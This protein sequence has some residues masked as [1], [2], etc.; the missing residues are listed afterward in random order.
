MYDYP[1]ITNHIP[2]YQEFDGDG[3]TIN[4][5][6][7]GYKGKSLHAV[8][9]RQDIEG[10]Q[11]AFDLGWIDPKTPH[12]MQTIGY[13]SLLDMAIRRGLSK[14]AAKLEEL[15]FSRAPGPN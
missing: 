6:M 5:D 13:S 11:K 15:G 14:T 12:H 8:I 4:H 10:I 2:G 9:T 3:N 7:F 1:K